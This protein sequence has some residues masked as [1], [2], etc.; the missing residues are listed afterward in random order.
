[1]PQIS[2]FDFIEELEQS[3]SLTPT[4]AEVQEVCAALE[5]EVVRPPR[6]V[7]REKEWILKQA[8]GIPGSVTISRIG[9]KHLAITPLDLDAALM[10][11]NYRYSE[12]DLVTERR[13]LKDGRQQIVV[14]FDG[15]KKEYTTEEAVPSLIRACIPMFSDKEND[16]RVFFYFENGYGPDVRDT[17]LVR[18]LQQAGFNLVIPPSFERW[19]RKEWAREVRELTPYSLPEIKDRRPLFDQMEEGLLVHCHTPSGEF[20]VNSTYVVTKLTDPN[21][22]DL[23]VQLQK[24]S[25]EGENCELVS[26]RITWL[27]N[28]PMEEVFSLAAGTETVYD[29]DNC[30]IAKYPR[31]HAQMHQRALAMGRDV[32]KHTAHDAAQMALKRNGLELQAPTHGQELARRS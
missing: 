1:M 7:F 21:G 25:G 30:L 18:H 32:Y 29:P 3:L 23:G 5:P 11:H 12:A 24:L 6:P 13:H 26:S 9:R 19:V 4:P 17:F 15:S 28:G 27:N 31:E 16:H 10:L 22:S 14:L 8:E 20:E 2:L